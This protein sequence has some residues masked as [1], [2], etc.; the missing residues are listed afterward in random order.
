M[1]EGGFQGFRQQFALY[2]APMAIINWAWNRCND[3]IVRQHVDAMITVNDLLADLQAI[4]YGVRRPR[5]VMNCPPRQ[6]LQADRSFLARKLGVPGETPIV[7]Y[8]G[9]ME[10]ERHG[11]GLENLIEC[12]PL[13]KR[14]AVTVLLGRGS[15]F[16]QLQQLAAKPIYEERVFVL[17]AVPPSQLMAHTVGATIGVIPTELWH[18]SL[19]FSSPNKLF[20]YLN[21][22]LPV[23]TSNLP[24][25]QR[26]CE[27][28]QCGLSCDPTLPQSIADAINQL[29]ENDNLYNSCC[30][31]ARRAAEF[32]NWERQEQ[33]LLDVYA[34]LT[35]QVNRNDPLAEEAI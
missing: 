19:R 32:Y 25:I 6:N 22:G 7:I 29:L 11:V 33:T 30:A 23:V 15:Q 3:W 20:E 35:G 10:R 1:E 13:L 2:P 12:A 31:G 24:I 8:Q 26:I 17:P 14:K 28:Y 27:E 21:A 16:T 34:E 9:M 4:H 18:P 5:L